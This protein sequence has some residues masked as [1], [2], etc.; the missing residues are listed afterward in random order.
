M[1]KFITAI[2]FM[3]AMLPA[4][5]FGQNQ[6]AWYYSLTQETGDRYTYMFH[7]DNL[8]PERDAIFKIQIDAPR[9]ASKWKVISSS[10]PTGW[11]NNSFNVQTAN[12]NLGSRN[13]G[14]YRIWGQSGTDTPPAPGNTSGTFSWTFLRNGGMMPTVDLFQSSD[15]K[16]HLQNIGCDWGNN[17]KTYTVVPGYKT[18]PAPVPEPS[19]VVSALACLSPAALFFRK[20]QSRKNPV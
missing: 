3:A 10:L 12:G 7:F 15:V 5:V 1:R 13:F 8:G 18:P 17:G 4:A 2:V 11:V 6:V 19:T 9:A 20:R 14:K 16:V